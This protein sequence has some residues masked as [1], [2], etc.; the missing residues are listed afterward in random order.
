[1]AA[2]PTWKGFM[3]GFFEQLTLVA[4]H[5]VDRFKEPRLLFRI[6]CQRTTDPFPQVR[7]RAGGFVRRVLSTVGCRNLCHMHLR[8]P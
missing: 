4:E 1:M 2:R 5:V 3:L 8:E 6:E 7:R